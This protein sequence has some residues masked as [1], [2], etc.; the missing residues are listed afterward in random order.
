LIDLLIALLFVG[1]TA[2]VS[3]WQGLGLERDIAVGTVRTFVQLLT[4]GFVL[5]RLFDASR[6]YW[7]V[8]AL[9]AMTTVAG[10]NAMKRQS[11][12]KQ[13]LFAV[14]TAAIAA[15]GGIA[16]MLVIGVV[17]RVRPW[18][19]PQYVIPIAGMIIGNSMTG[20]ALVVNRFHS[21]LTLRRSEVEASLALGATSREAAAGALRESLRAAMMPTINSMMTVGLV[22]LPGMMTGQIIS[23]VSPLDAVRYQVVV[24]LM[25]AAATAVTAMTAAFGT[26]GVFFTPAQQL[27]PRLELGRHWDA[28]RARTEH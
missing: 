17:L 7:V 26:L 10:Y 18:Y 28:Y 24:M 8:A 16:L 27:S 25:I 13:G 6:W 4:V 9:A 2:L 23:G 22:Q 11:G 14:M 12:A 21:E 19:Q 3:Y 15:G 20:A 1:V 5:Q